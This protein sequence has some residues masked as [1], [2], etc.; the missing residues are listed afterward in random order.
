M[1]IQVQIL[2]IE[3]DSLLEGLAK[4]LFNKWHFQYFMHGWP[5]MW[6]KIKHF[7][8][9]FLDLLRVVAVDNWNLTGH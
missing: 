6:L 4:M 8:Y 2:V 3:I 1:I 9:K 5:S 7:N